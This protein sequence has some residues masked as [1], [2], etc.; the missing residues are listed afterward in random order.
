MKTLA[1]GSLVK[2]DRSRQSKFTEDD[3][4]RMLVKVAQTNA[5]RQ[6]LKHGLVK[7]S[8]PKITM[9]IIDEVSD[10]NPSNLKKKTST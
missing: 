9:P 6:R 8:L 5:T 1:F 4:K 7:L 10:A 2:G 3:G